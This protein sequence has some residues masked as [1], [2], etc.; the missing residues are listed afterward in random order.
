[1]RAGLG[2]QICMAVLLVVLCATVESHRGHHT[3][4]FFFLKQNLIIMDS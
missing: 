4:V 1:M 2:A 3:Q